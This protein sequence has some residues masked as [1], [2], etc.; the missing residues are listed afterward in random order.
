MSTPEWTPE[1]DAALY[2]LLDEIEKRK[3][4][5]GITSSNDIRAQCDG[6]KAA[7][8]IVPR[9]KRRVNRTYYGQCLGSALIFMGIAWLFAYLFHWD[10]DGWDIWFFVGWYTG[11]ASWWKSEAEK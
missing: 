6:I 9:T 4:E 1:K 2:G 8:N 3:Q 11:S 7:L 5:A 10:H